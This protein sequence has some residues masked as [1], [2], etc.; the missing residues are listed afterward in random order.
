MLNDINILKLASAFARYASD[1][2][3]LV[4]QNIANADANNYKAK[5]LEP[6]TETYKR[7]SAEM[8]AGGSE[9]RRIW[10]SNRRGALK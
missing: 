5:D 1:R 4:A 2:H 7:Q 6:F 3:Q 10:R 9:E 8:L